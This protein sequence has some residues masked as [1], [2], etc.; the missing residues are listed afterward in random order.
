[1]RLLPCLCLCVLCCN[2]LFMNITSLLSRRS[3]SSPFDTL[4]NLWANTKV[5]LITKS[6]VFPIVRPRAKRKLLLSVFAA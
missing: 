4:C 3:S 5:K 2:L 6:N 1:M